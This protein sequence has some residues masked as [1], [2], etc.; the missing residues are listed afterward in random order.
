MVEKDVSRRDFLKQSALGSAAVAGMGAIAGL[1]T[2]AAGAE[3]ST[4]LSYQESRPFVQG[5]F[6]LAQGDL[7]EADFLRARGR[8]DLLHEWML[9]DLPPSEFFFSSALAGLI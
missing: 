5:I 8:M 4:A 1:P 9:Q 3:E 2:P 6:D 7:V